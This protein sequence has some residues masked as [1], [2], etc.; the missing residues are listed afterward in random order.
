MKKKSVFGTKTFF[1]GRVSHPARLIIDLNKKKGSLAGCDQARG[2]PKRHEDALRG[3][4][5]LPRRPEEARRGKMG[6][7]RRPEEGPKGQNGVP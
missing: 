7:P 4:M 1:L 2:S 3:R 6:L 5:G